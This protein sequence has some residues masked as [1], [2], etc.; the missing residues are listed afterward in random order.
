[1]TERAINRQHPVDLIVVEDS[2]VDTELMVD[3]LSEAGLVVEVRRV[4]DELALLA[5][6]EQRWPDA[7]LSD[8]TLPRFSG[9]VALEIMHVYCPQVPFIFVSGSISETTAI[10]ALRRGAIDYVYKHQLQQLAPALIRALD[11]ARVLCA[12]R[13]SEVLNRAILDSVD[14]QIAVLD[15][16][17]VIIATNKPWRRFALENAVLPGVQLLGLNVGSN[18]LAACQSADAV[19]ED[20]ALK[21]HDGIQGV[22]AG[23]L[24]SFSFEYPCHSPL[25]R[26][27]FVMSVTPLDQAKRGVVVT[28]AEITGRKT[29]ELQ[30]RQLSQVVEQSPAS[31]L[32]TD[33]DANIDYANE[34]FIAACGYRRDEILGQNPRFLQSGKTPPQTY[35]ALWQAMQ[36]GESWTGEFNNRRKD[37]SDYIESAIITPMRQADGLITHYVAVQEDITEQKRLGLELDGH[38]NHLEELVENRTRELRAAQKQAEAANQA[39]SSFLANMSHEI[40][41]PMNAMIGLTHLLRRSGVTAEQAVRLDKIDSAGHH[42]LAIINDILDISKIEAGQV[43]L[44]TTDFYLSSILDNVVSLIGEQARSKGLRVEIDPDSVPVWLHGDATRL[45]QALLNYAGNA[46][47]FTEQGSITLRAI[48]LEDPGDDG[49][50]LLVRFEVE[51]TGIGIAVDKLPGLFQE[52]AQADVSTTRKYGGTGL[53]LAITRRLAGLMGGQADVVSTLGAG[54]TFWFTARLSRGRGVM[55]SLVAEVTTD[56]ETALRRHYRSAR[57]LLV[58]DN[59]INREIAL[60][61]LHS[62]GL[63]ADTA[64]DGRIALAKVAA[65]DYDLVLMDMQMPEMD[66]ADATRAI[67]LLPGRQATPILAMTANAFAG[68]RRACLEAGMDDFVAKPVDPDV[69]FA[70][71]L[72]WLPQP[73]A[74]L[75][76]RATPATP[77]ADA[78]SLPG[79]SPETAGAWSVRPSVLPGIDLAVGRRY[80][81]GRVDFH[82]KMLKKFRDDLATSVMADFR[83]ARAA[84]DWPTVVRMAHALKGSA[85]ILGATTLADIAGRLE[86]AARERNL[87]QVAGLEL[88]LDQEVALIVSGLSGLE[89]IEARSTAAVSSIDCGERRD[90]FLRFAQLLQARDTAATSYLG[91]FTRVT[92]GPD[93]ASAAATISRFVARYDFAEALR[94][95][96]LLAITLDISLENPP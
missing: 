28:H 77:V 3:A 63:T 54:S 22:L 45:R 15:H 19:A 81:G 17:G 44:E 71:L 30:L 90:V 16:D 34:A 65:N 49:D 43:K 46:V 48:L 62:V 35:A 42:L 25:Q 51:D 61:L 21:A 74:E 36:R 85:A 93:G 60:E 66:G 11:E 72:K 2:V 38:R 4:D 52:F 67:R 27:W 84:Y 47:K 76:A 13:D 78:G 31:I 87:A 8:W 70:A 53:G 23:Q 39:K 83:A 41:T 89:A 58:E 64:D 86:Q 88:A 56:A 32:I 7:I 12:L 26:R 73:S 6:L 5:A 37:G 75:V 10:E 40:R 24:T 29:A 95:L 9:A 20:G 79:S 18:Y 57:L 68:D 80:L 91:E 50:E 82:L 94:E 59:E 55:P 14:A 69:L 96:R 33:L 1:M 92:D